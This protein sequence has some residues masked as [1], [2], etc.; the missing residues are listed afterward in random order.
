MTLPGTILVRPDLVAG[1][2]SGDR[3]G[4]LRHEIVHLAQWRRHG[5]VRF[6]AS[7]LLQYASARMA[8]MP[9]DVAYRGI[10]FERQAISAEAG[11]RA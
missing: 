8:G 11:P 10:S 3:P 4:L 6:L 2:V 7:Y 1:V 5:A 9:H